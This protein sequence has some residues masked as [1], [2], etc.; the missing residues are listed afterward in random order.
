MQRTWILFFWW[1]YLDATTD[2]NRHW[3]IFAFHTVSRIDLKWALVKKCHILCDCISRA[4]KTC[5]SSA[6]FLLVSLLENL[7]NG[8]LPSLVGHNGLPRARLRVRKS[9]R[10]PRASRN[11]CPWP[12]S[13]QSSPSCELATSAFCDDASDAHLDSQLADAPPQHYHHFSQLAP[14]Q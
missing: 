9:L 11:G 8:I 10:G 4:G 1:C 12:E 5:H 7:Q 6:P 3:I 13:I 2:L 14:E